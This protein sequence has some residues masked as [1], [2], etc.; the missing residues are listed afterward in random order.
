M[1]LLMNGVIYQVF[2]KMKIED[3]FDWLLKNVISRMQ[4]SGKILNACYENII[5][6]MTVCQP[7]FLCH[8]KRR[9]KNKDKWKSESISGLYL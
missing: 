6:I 8:K 9:N 5:P 7:L 3:D 1:Q 2:G 4:I